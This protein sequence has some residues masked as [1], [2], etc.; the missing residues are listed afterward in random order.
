MGLV[1]SSNPRIH[2]LLLES[3][4]VER[5]PEEQ[6][7]RVDVLG[8]V[9]PAD[10]RIHVELLR[11]ARDSNAL[12]GKAALSALGNIGSSDPQVHLGLASLLKVPQLKE[13]AIASLKRTP[14]RSPEV[15]QMILEAYEQEKDQDVKVELAALFKEH[16]DTETSRWLEQLLIKRGISKDSVICQQLGSLEPAKV[17]I[18]EF[19]KLLNEI[20]TYLKRE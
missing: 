16:A 19:Q 5:E 14:F 9:K 7:M 10:P 18:E 15:Y 12:V 1:Q 2:E 6:A 20:S 17:S 3:V 4:R 13:S 11:M 8:R